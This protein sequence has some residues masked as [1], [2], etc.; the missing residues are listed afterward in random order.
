MRSWTVHLPP[1]AARGSVPATGLKQISAAAQAP[2][3]SIYHHFPGG[4]E[5]LGDEVIRQAG[6]FFRVLV[7]AVYEAERDP[8]T[9]SFN[10]RAERRMAWAG[11]VIGVLAGASG[12]LFGWSSNP[13]M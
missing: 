4:K 13:P 6:E 3:G 2:F 9:A 8:V 12:L 7:Q 5:Q 11:F 1:G 10:R